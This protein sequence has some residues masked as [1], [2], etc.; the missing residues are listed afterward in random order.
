MRAWFAEAIETGIERGEFAGGAE[1]DRVADRVLALADGY[2]VRVLFGDM[3]ADDAR[4]EIWIALR[5]ELGLP[6]QPPALLDPAHP[7]D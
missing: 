2:G 1:P 3:E 4:R 7:Q 5:D 6:D